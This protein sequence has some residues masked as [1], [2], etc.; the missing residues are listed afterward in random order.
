MSIFDKGFVTII[1][2]AALLV[3]VATPLAFRKVPRNFVYGYRTRATMTDDDTWFEA[4]AHFGRGLIIA[5]L[6]G[7]F[8][9]YLI[10]HFQPFSPSVFLP[11]SVLALVIPSLAAAVATARFV[12]S[13]DS[14]G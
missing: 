5:S 13:M 7:A 1:A 6:C 11:I 14:S 12:R 9:A 10:Y 8:A 2:C 4:N 3:L